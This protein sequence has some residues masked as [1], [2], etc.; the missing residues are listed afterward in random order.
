MAAVHMN[1]FVNELNDLYVSPTADFMPE[2]PCLRSIFSE[3]WD[4]KDCL[5]IKW[6]Q[7]EY[8]YIGFAPLN[9]RCKGVIFGRLDLSLTANPVEFIPATGR[10]R[11]V[12][13]IVRS[14]GRLE[15]ALLMMATVVL[16]KCQSFYVHIDCKSPPIPQKFGLIRDH[17]TKHG[18]MKAFRRSHAAFIPLVGWCAWIFASAGGEL[19]ASIPRWYDLLESSKRVHPEWLNEMCR[20][21]LGDFS[22]NIQRVGMFVHLARCSWMNI[23]RVYVKAKIPIWLY[24]GKV[25]VGYVKNYDKWVSRYKPSPEAAFEAARKYRMTMVRN[26]RETSDQCDEAQDDNNNSNYHSLSQFPPPI[27]KSGQRHGEHWHDFC[28][29]IEQEQQVIA[30]RETPSARLARLDREKH[31]ARHPFPGKKGPLCFR[32]ELVDGFRIRTPLTRREAEDI[33]DT[34]PNQHR[35]YNSFANVWDINPDFDPEVDEDY[36]SEDSMTEH[37]PSPIPSSLTSDPLPMSFDS[38][39][40]STPQVPLELLCPP[41]VQPISSSRSFVFDDLIKTVGN[42]VREPTVVTEAM[43]DN[44]FF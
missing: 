15:H 39:S 28:A 20:N 4:P 7:N 8:P 5:S 1:V 18:V 30:Q 23:I 14:W 27:S 21:E 36:V 35:R 25:G 22:G 17:K 13:E 42:A 24:W 29:R 33:W 44:L 16:D 31:Q 32:W 37:Y 10:W 26:N 3:E 2:V 38:D 6:D 19:C 34:I 12:P 43:E 9:L 40:D 41:E 11:V